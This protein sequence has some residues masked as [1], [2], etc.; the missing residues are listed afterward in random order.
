MTDPDSIGILAYDG[1]DARSLVDVHDFVVRAKRAGCAVRV[2]VFSLVPT[3]SVTASTGIGI[4]PDDVLI[5]TPDVVVVPG[6]QSSGDE[7]ASRYPQELPDRVAQLAA[8]GATLVGIGSGALALG[9]AG[10]L[11]DRQATTSQALRDALE[12]HATSVVDDSVVESDGVFTATG[13]TAALAVTRRVL[14]KRCDGAVLSRV[15][16]TVGAD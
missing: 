15:A 6:G 3:G 7:S 11:T 16:A 13:P 4:E 14:E 9:E 10:L 1:I 12:T 5:G 8:A 2:T